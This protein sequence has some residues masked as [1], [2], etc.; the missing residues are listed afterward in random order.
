MAKAN[1]IK[2]DLVRHL[3]GTGFDH[4]N[5]IL[6]GGQG[7]IHITLCPFLHI[8][9]NDGLSVNKSQNDT[10]NGAIKRNIRNSQGCRRA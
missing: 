10:G 2:H 3:V 1:G 4:D 9:V 8:G 6:V 7:D 5:L